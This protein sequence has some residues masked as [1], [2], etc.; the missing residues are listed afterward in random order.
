[1]VVL[2]TLAS[3]IALGWD[4]GITVTVLFFSSSGVTVNGT[5][6]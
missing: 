5:A 4:F 2:V 1:M 6:K 3:A